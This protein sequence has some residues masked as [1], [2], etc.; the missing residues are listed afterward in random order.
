MVKLSQQQITIPDQPTRP[1]RT[2]RL[3]AEQE[4][5]REQK[6]ASMEV[7]KREVLQ[8][9]VDTASEKFK[10]ISYEDYEKEYNKLDAE[11]KQ[12]F[13]SPTELKKTPEYQ[14][15]QK[16]LATYKSKQEAYESAV[17]E[18]QEW[19]KAQSI[20]FRGSRYDPQSSVGKKVNQIYKHI[21]MTNE[22]YA[23]AKAKASQLKQE[24]EM[25]K[26]ELPSFL[27][28]QSTPLDKLLGQSQATSFSPKTTT[29]STSF[30]QPQSRVNPLT[31]KPEYVLKSGITVPVTSDTTKALSQGRSDLDV[32]LAS[33]K[34]EQKQSIAP[35]STVEN[36]EEQKPVID[37]VKVGGQSD[38]KWYDKSL[39]ELFIS[40]AREK[41]KTGAS[42]VGGVVKSGFEYVDERVHFDIGGT[43]TSPKLTVSFGKRE[44]PTI[45]EQLVEMGQEGLQGYKQD[46]INWAIGKE[47][48]EDIDARLQEK[49]QM[50]Y[51]TAFEEQFVDQDFASESDFDKAVEKFGKSEKAKGIIEEY[52][53]EYEEEYV[54][55][56]QD[57]SLT[58]KI[59]GGSAV[60]GLSL[61]GTGLELAKTPTRVAV[62][63]SAVYTGGST[64]A[65]IPTHVALVTGAGLGV[66]GTYKAFSP[67]ST[68]EEAGS[69]FVTAILSGATLG[70]AGYKYLRSPVVSTEIIKAPKIDLKASEVIGE[71]LKLISQEGTAE[72]VI[73]NEQKLLQTTSEGRRTIV[74]SKGRQIFDLD[75]LY[76][77]VPY[78]DAK[79]YQQALK[80][81]MKYGYSESEARSTLRYVSPKI[82]EQYL[83]KGVIA[84]EGDKALAEF[85]YLTKRPII[86]LDKELGIKTRGA[87]IIKDVYD[88]ERKIV[89]IKDTGIVAEE[90]F[91]LS[92][93]SESK[94]PIL[95]GKILDLGGGD[96]PVK[97]ADIVID[98][99]SKLRLLRFR[100]S[101]KRGILSK[102]Y[103]KADYN[104]YIP[105]GDESIK[106][107]Y[108]KYSLDVFGE[109]KAYDEAYR[110]LEKGGK[111]KITSGAVED[112][113][114]VIR[115]L[116]KAGFEQTKI[117]PI[118]KGGDVV[119]TA[120][121]YPYRKFYFDIKNYEYSRGFNVGKAT[122]LQKG[123]R[124]SGDKTLRV[125]EEA[126]IQDLYSASFSRRLLP[127]ENAL[128][129]D[130]SKTRLIQR[131]IDR[132]LKGSR[133]S[134]T[135]RTPLSKTFG[136]EDL[137]DLK[138]IIKEK[139]TGKV[140]QVVNKIEEP[141][142]ATPRQLQQ[143]DA[144][145]KN[146]PSPEIRSSGK[147]KTD[148]KIKQIEEASGVKVSMINLS[149]LEQDLKLKEVL[150]QDIVSRINLKD[151]AKTDIDLALK[152]ASALK[153]PTALKQKVRA[154]LDV[155]S[156]LDISIRSPLPN[157]PKIPD[158]SKPNVNLKL[159]LKARMGKKER[160]LRKGQFEEFALLPD[161]TSRALGLDPDIVSGKQAQ[162]RIKKILTGLE[163]RKGAVIK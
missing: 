122:D 16:D 92:F 159:L 28:Y 104:E 85:S 102:K 46:V 68:V 57:A 73:F 41:V 156:A 99:M 27:Q 134:G 149:K 13:V 6:Y 63:S 114:K 47:N 25:S 100:Y 86:E 124:V 129:I 153:T 76:E 163:L 119:I 117:T 42:K 52:G 133:P 35:T 152:E 94:R 79:G 8:K 1:T 143:L 44:E 158:V 31:N 80:K 69:G 45:P 148:V 11:T 87:R 49:Y 103:L 59:I 135:R 139:P 140:D 77:G 62:V 74:T 64:L 161:F 70:Y 34:S 90:R 72:R 118:N 14:Q 84:I 22:Y 2:Q 107:I 98:E 150:K 82:T 32:L 61:G 75:N 155:K 40:P 83:E 88:V 36:Y 66:Y 65:L 23:S 138:K 43:A 48:I 123:F 78:A 121:K 127:S 18:A 5:A 10:D 81:L 29:S 51:Q 96:Y 109:Q 111:I 71:D 101:D 147:I 126:D 54:A 4:Q 30:N 26:P 53:Q 137:G 144:Q 162:A 95:K 97:N 106:E 131:A 142:I 105:L 160:K 112:A 3:L 12:F 116:N 20:V 38:D 7:G 125:F 39:E 108:S 89:N 9:K 60:V 113:Q 55:L 130:T 67:T 56:S 37:A 19:E 50:K 110:I 141:N 15:Y 24:Q 91:G 146:A 151:V 58:K 120:T 157:L 145:L 17:K 93:I 132:T 21:E 115:K 33:K 136:E 154:K 128:R